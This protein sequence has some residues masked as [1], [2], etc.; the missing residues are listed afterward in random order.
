MQRFFDYYSVAVLC[1]FF[2]LVASRV[3]IL[4]RRGIR[5]F[6]FGETDK[7]DFLLFPAVLIMIYTVLAS[8]FAWPYPQVLIR[9]L[10]EHPAMEWI[11][12]VLCLAGLVG[13][14]LSLVS[15]GNSFRVGIDIEKPDKL[16]TSGMFAVSR[17]PL[18]VS[19]IALF[20]GL[21]LMHFNP[22]SVI[23]YFVFFIPVVHRQVMR[24]EKFMRG[25]YGEEYA[26]YCRKVR[27]YL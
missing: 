8:A 21:M 27:R 12:A 15:F 2:L 19:F 6:V 14:L 17:N 13:L 3:M 1:C 25:H 23:L 20:G 5:A 7:T 24:E 16:I 10:F 26:D 11:G 18:Y 4:R 9:P 22:A